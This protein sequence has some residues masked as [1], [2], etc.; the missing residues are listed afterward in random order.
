MVW[1]WYAIG[2]ALLT[3]AACSFFFALAESAL[4]A[5][6]RFRAQQMLEDN[7]E[8]GQ[9]IA[10]LFQKPED[11]VATLAFG[12][13]VANAT[14]IGL[15]VWVLAHTY[16][17]QFFTGISV[18]V[19]ILVVCE[20]IPKALGVRAPEFWAV[21]VARSVRLL[22]AI[23]S[24]LRRVAQTLN[25]IIMRL[26][27][28]KSIQ[29]HPVISEE[30]Y[31]EL[32]SIAEQQG[33][34]NRAEKDILVQILSLDKRTAGDVMK[35][36]SQ[37]TC[38]SDD[39]SREEMLEA[40]R[41]TA[42]TRIPIYDETPDTIVGVLNARALL[43]NPDLDLEEVI[44]F[45]SFVPQS[46]N[47]LHLLRSLQRQQ[48]GL[49]IVLDEFGGTAGLVT[50]EDILEETL[51]RFQRKE[52]AGKVLERLGPGK[53]RVDGACTLDEFRR[54]F[55]ALKDADDVDTMSGLFVQ[56]MEYV[57]ASGEWVTVQG[58]R[59]TAQEVEDRRVRQLEVEVVK[60]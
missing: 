47:L 40:A 12:N 7:P 19:F 2:G 36:R 20:V 34:L 37:I 5:L 11:L 41:K 31:Q 44:E 8:S 30:E 18:L 35:A 24:P 33:A 15:T 6:G 23:T 59:L 10:P 45:P 22:V 39:L 21:R 60:R 14:I 28:P 51:G 3:A 50:M 27:I 26:I 4:F 17:V 13:T 54:E 38:I 48:R 16:L 46:M 43:L 55:P 32:L 56:Q 52:A 57:P 29:P 53:W 58:L 9:K 42:H 49:A 25:D 1:S